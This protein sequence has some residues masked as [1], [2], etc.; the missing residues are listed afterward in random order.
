MGK[1]FV[2]EYRI[3][4]DGAALQSKQ[5]KMK[6]KIVTRD[7]LIYENQML[8]TVKYNENKCLKYLHNG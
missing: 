2:I 8:M 7:N 5:R 4:I 3:Q 6:I 1:L